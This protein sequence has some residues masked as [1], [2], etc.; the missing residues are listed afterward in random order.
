MA[1]Y[2]S[3]Y[4]RQVQKNDKQSNWKQAENFIPLKGEVIVYNKDEFYGKPRMKIGDGVTKVNDLPFL[5]PEYGSELPV[6]TGEY[7]PVEGDMFLLE[8]DI[9]SSE[10]V[11]V[12]NYVYHCGQGPH[13]NPN[14]CLVS[15]TRCYMEFY[16]SSYCPEEFFNENHST[17]ADS[18]NPSVNHL[19]SKNWQVLSAHCVTSGPY[20]CSGITASGHCISGGIWMGT[21]EQPSAVV[22]VLIALI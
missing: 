9:D 13:T 6:V 2:N 4:S 18:S 15:K 14:K 12:T 10:W 20:Y 3:V 17:S 8:Q 22:G 7:A 11:D 5:T 21:S 1:Q 19:L 16:L